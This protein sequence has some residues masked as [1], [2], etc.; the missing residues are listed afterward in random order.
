M[1]SMPAP[2]A[3]TPPMHQTCL[4]S[5]R[6]GSSPAPAVGCGPITQAVEFAATVATATDDS[7]DIRRRIV[8]RIIGRT[9][10]IDELARHAL[11]GHAVL[12]YGPR[13]IGASAVLDGCARELQRAGRRVV[14]I[15]RLASYSD[16]MDPLGR[17]YSGGRRSNKE[18]LHAS[19]EAAP[20]AVLVDRIESAGAKL[21]RAIRELGAVGLGAVLVGQAE[22]PREHARLRALR[23][24]HREVEIPPLDR[25]AMRAVL[26]QHAVG[27]PVARLVEADR[28]RVLE[29]ANGRPGTLVALVRLLSQ[30][31]Y[32]RERRAAV[33]LAVLDLAIADLAHL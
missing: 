24:A 33:D 16:L 8:M 1:L 23:V 27:T 28:D 26:D 7:F 13:G 2:T 19:I 31:R 22:A 30:P 3:V 15:A 6:T 10:L 25:S 11:E 5:T 17:A 18:Q 14:R 9:T 12:A 21:R 29:A 20:G 32:W 4:L